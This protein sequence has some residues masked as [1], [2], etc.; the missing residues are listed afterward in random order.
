MDGGEA[1]SRS[2]RSRLPSLLDSEVVEYPPSELLGYDALEQRVKDQL[3]ERD[4]PTVLLGESFSGPLAI[5][6]GAHPP[7]NVVG[8]VLVATFAEPPAPRWLK[9]LIGPHIFWFPPLRGIIRKYLVGN[10]APDELVEEVRDAIRNVQPKV[11]AHRLREVFGVDVRAE[12]RQVSIPIL[13][14]DGSHDRVVRSHRS[15]HRKPGMN[16]KTIKAPHLVL[17]ARPEEASTVVAE[18][19]QGLCDHA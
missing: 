11:L 19:I 13:C 4:D 3:A 16:R 15:L 2:F 17:Q 5:R 6:I 1:L 14:L 12:L 8:I 10:D 18:F 7:L 9:Q